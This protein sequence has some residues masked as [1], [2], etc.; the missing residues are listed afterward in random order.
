MGR[1]SPPP[2]E[3]REFRARR[4]YALLVGGKSG[5]GAEA[6]GALWQMPVLSGAVRECQGP[7]AHS[8]LW[9]VEALTAW[10]TGERRGSH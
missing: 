1:N 4:T 6:L 10:W 7:F 9:D 2:G 3:G 5:P 8:V